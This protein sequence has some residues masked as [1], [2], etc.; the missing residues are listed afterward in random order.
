MNRR[1]FAAMLACLGVPSGGPLFASE[2]IDEPEILLLSRNGWMP[3]N[4]RLPVLLYRN[5]ISV[6]G[7]DPAR[8]FEQVFERNGWPPQWRNGVYSFHHYHSTSHEV[9]GFAGGQA[10]LMLGG[11]SGHEVSVQAGD[12]A[13]LPTGTGHCKLTS[14]ADFLVVGAYPPGQD[15]DICRSA[16]DR[17][18]VERMGKL[19][20]PNS[21]PVSG[22]GGALTRRWRAAGVAGRTG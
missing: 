14:S 6:T 15:W 3:N 2:K 17:E 7:N 22:A 1:E 8:A 20:F 16:P 21:D 5:V 13:V 10:K 4:E 11:E 12:V 9:L 19:I 18:S